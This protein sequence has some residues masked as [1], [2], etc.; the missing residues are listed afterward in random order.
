MDILAL[1]TIRIHR[2]KWN[3]NKAM[4]LAQ[5]YVEIVQNKYPM[6]PENLSTYFVLPTFE[7]VTRYQ[8]IVVFNPT[9]GSW[10]L[11]TTSL[12]EHLN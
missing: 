8:P 10:E 6:G 11:S 2:W 5:Q 12:F 3:R 9:E 4:K 1:R 7:H